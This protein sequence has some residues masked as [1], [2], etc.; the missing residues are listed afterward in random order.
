MD[1]VEGEFCAEIV[2]VLC[3]ESGG[4]IRGHTDLTGGAEDRVSLERDNVGRGGIVEELTMELGE[5]GIGDKGEGQ[6]TRRRAVEEAVSGSVQQVND[7]THGLAI[8]FEARVRVVDGDFAQQT[9][10]GK[11]EG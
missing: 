6:F 10:R 5:S 4:S 9:G 3:G 11:Q 1:D 7:A 2:A 8:D